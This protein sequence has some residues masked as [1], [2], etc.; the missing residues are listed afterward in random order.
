MVFYI[1][2]YMFVYLLIVYLYL[3]ADGSLHQSLA[4]VEAILL[5]SMCADSKAPVDQRINDDDHHHEIKDD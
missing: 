3:Y 1:Y 5:D 2:I 4:S